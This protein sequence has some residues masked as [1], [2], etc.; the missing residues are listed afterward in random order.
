MKKMEFEEWE[1]V[2]RYTVNYSLQ[3]RINFLKD[4]E[5]VFRFQTMKL[6][7]YNQN[8]KFRFLVSVFPNGV[9]KETEGWLVVLR[10]VRIPK[11]EPRPRDYGILSH[12]VSVIDT[13]GNSRLPRSFV[14]IPSEE[15]E[16]FPK[17][18]ERSLIFNRKDEFLS[19]GVLTVRCDIHFYINTIFSEG[20][21]HRILKDFLSS[22]PQEF[23][24]K[25][26]AQ[27]G[28]ADDI[29]KRDPRDAFTVYDFTH[30][31]LTLPPSH[32]S[33]RRF[34][35][36][37][38]SSK[39]SSFG[40]D[41][42]EDMAD[43]L[44]HVWIFDTETVRFLVSLDELQDGVGARLLKASPV[45]RRMVNAPMKE[46]LEKHI[47]FRDVS[48]RTFIIVLFFLEKGTLPASPNRDFLGVYKFS[49]FHEMEVLQRKCAEEMV[50][51]V[52]FSTEELKRTADDYSDEYLT[53]LL[54]SR[55]H[56]YEDS[57]Q[58]RFRMYE[59]LNSDSYI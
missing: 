24:Y 21:I 42:E 49:H 17:Y 53:E 30:R 15:D 28:D 31:I 39:E 18:L 13:E 58:P 25:N 44:E 54:V 40:S 34:G 19:E 2:R 36:Y 52:E 7:R 22:I 51:S 5:K 1:T 4:V 3:L 56:E 11:H 20:F 10:D 50:K 48:S 33:R 57:E 45:I 6:R 46:R 47:H 37:S 27:T 35:I 41:S 55:W 9:N 12:T 29:Y 59:R 16:R 8:F 26:E 43:I 32:E 14:E 23:C 38:I